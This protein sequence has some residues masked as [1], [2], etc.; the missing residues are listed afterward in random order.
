MQSDLVTRVLLGAIVLCLLLLIGQR[1]LQSGPAE[2]ALSQ[3]PR[4]Q[5]QIQGMRKGGPLLVKTDLMSGTVWRK[6][7]I[8]DGPWVTVD[9][10]SRG[11]GSPAD[12]AP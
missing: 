2:G 4:F 6:S 12:A 9:A 11:E 7:L 1:N 5:V 8:G 10:E 3:Q